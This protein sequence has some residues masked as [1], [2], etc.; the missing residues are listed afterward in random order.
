MKRSWFP[1]MDIPSGFRCRR[2]AWTRSGASRK[3][4][5]ERGAASHRNCGLSLRCRRRTRGLIPV[6]GSPQRFSR[7][8]PHLDRCYQR[9][10][11]ETVRAFLR[12]ESHTKRNT[13]PTIARIE[14]PM[15]AGIQSGDSTHH[16]DHPIFPSSL[17][18]MNT[19][20]SS[21]AKPIPLDDEDEL[22]IGCSMGGGWTFLLGVVLG[23][24][25]WFRFWV[26]DPRRALA[27]VG[28]VVQAPVPD[29]FVS[30]LL[31]VWAPRYIGRH[32]QVFQAM[33]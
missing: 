20:V 5:P 16:Q 17:R 11:A 24:W 12:S 6:L 7:C 29:D 13:I 3:G 1:L 30:A 31:A 23:F 28:V 21:P 33:R 25:D 27:P 4:F 14:S 8:L 26:C 2:R 32:G 9:R 15:D 19:M 18:V 10:N 22:L